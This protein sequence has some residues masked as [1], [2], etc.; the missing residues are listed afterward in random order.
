MIAGVNSPESRYREI[1][2]TLSAFGAESFISLEQ[3]DMDKA[4]GL[5]FPG[6]F[7]D[8]NPALWGEENTCSNDINDRLDQVQLAMMKKAEEEKKPVLG[9]CRGM[10]LINVYFGGSVI[11]DLPCGEFHRKSNPEK[12]HQVSSVKGTFMEELFGESTSVNTR[13]HQSVNCIGRGLEETAFWYGDNAKV[14]EA[15]KHRTLPVLGVQWHPETM[16][17]E[18]NE[19]RKN[20]GKKI[21]RYFLD[22]V[23]KQGEK[24]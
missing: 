7:Q 4:D 22:F 2:D 16:C 23:D 8:I 11:Q 20:N 17:M 12:Y 1:Q 3:E 24:A 5:I 19:Q 15:V 10:Q 6:S 9:I 21:F 18:E 14:T 13:H